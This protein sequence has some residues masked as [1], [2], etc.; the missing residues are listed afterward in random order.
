MYV[1]IKVLYALL[2]IQMDVTIKALRT[3]N[4]T[5]GRQH[6]SSMNYW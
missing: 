3:A 4:S 1:S 2:A 5:N 6:Q